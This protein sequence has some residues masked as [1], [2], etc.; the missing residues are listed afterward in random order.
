MA[1]VKIC[2]LTNFADLRT[3]VELG[4]DFAGFVFYPGSPRAVT[5]AAVGDIV[6]RARRELRPEVRYV[7]VFVDE[8]PEVV[9]HTM[10]G[11]GLDLAQLHGGETPE[12][13]RSLDLP[14]WKAVRVQDGSSLPDL[15]AYG[16]EAVLLD[17]F[18]AGAFGG[19]GRRFPPELARPAM[20]PGRKVILA[21]GISAA[22]LS[23][24]LALRPWAIDVSSSLEARPGRKSGR[25]M[26]EFFAAL[27]GAGGRS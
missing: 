13:C 7:G 11:C 12:Y 1:K 17:A 3:A 5:P 21:G 10:D 9:R 24:V 2:G 14:Y 26:K 18:S 23:D 22:N 20:T 4:A 8:R 25:K 16:G 27:D 19:T 6:R 15:D